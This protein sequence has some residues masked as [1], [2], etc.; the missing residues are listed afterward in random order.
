[1]A[2]QDEVQQSSLVVHASPVA[3]QQNDGDPNG[4]QVSPG[5]QG[6]PPPQYSQARPQHEPPTQ[7]ID[8]GR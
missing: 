7:S 1:L 4:V 2:V 6:T 8:A 5:Q 3:M